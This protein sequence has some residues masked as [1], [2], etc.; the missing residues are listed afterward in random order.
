MPI[1]CAPA[2]VVSR[3]WLAGETSSA[4]TTPHLRRQHP[5]QHVET[6]ADLLSLCF[7]GLIG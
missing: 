3:R 7:F 6:V 4:E 1:A 2:K 5:G